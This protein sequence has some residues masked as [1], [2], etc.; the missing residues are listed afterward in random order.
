MQSFAYTASGKNVTQVTLVYH[1]VKFYALIHWGTQIGELYSPLSH[2]LFTEVCK[3]NNIQRISRSLLLF[4]VKLDGQ[5]RA[6]RE[7]ARRRKSEWKVNLGN[8][9]S[10]RSNDS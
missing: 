9:N 1:H 7:A 10:S 8:G 4:K 3:I 5:G 6:R 2:P